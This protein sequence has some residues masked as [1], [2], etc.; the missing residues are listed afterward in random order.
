MKI[1]DVESFLMASPRRDYLFV[2]VS[3]D[4]GVH[5]GGEAVLSALSAIEHALWDITGKAYGQPVYRLLG[6]AVRD[7]I[8]CYTHSGDVEATL[9]YMEQG[10]RAFKFG[11]AVQRGASLTGERE[12]VR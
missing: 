9:R 3:T 5:G 7:Y 4:E 8:P 2:K 12:L 10:W 1:T 11:P 6:G